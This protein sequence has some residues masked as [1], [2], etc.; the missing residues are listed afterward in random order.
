MRRLLTAL[1]LSM[2]AIGLVVAPASPASAAP[3]DDESAFVRKINQLRASKGLG[4]LRVDGE[5]TGIGRRWAAK[6]A[7]AGQIS[8]N[9]NF[10]NEVS[11][12]WAKLGEN[13]GVGSN[14]DE[15]HRAFVNSPAHYRNLVDGDFTH[16]GVGVVYAGDGS[17]YTSHQFMRLRGASAAPAPTAAPKPAA[18]PRPAAPKPAAAP[19]P[20]T[21]PA[22]APA[23]AAAPVA[24]S[25]PVA[26]A[27]AAPPVPS[28][29]LVLVLEELRRIGAYRR[30][31]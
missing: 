23:A 1:L 14:V 5:L 18:A 25:A 8:H 24:A 12:D 10:P 13:V 28:L 30:G 21:R 26:A 2:L 11:Q 4:P 19:R 17:L 29:R 22:A 9:K 3:A 6:M 7:S 15:L 31:V 20:A 16:I 27:P